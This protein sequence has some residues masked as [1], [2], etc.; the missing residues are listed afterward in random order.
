M[1]KCVIFT[2]K[3]FRQLAKEL[4]PGVVYRLIRYICFWRGKYF[5][6]RELSRRKNLSIFDV[7]ELTRDMDLVTRE[8]GYNAFYG[9]NIIINK[10]IG[11]RG[12]VIGSIEHGV[13]YTGQIDNMTRRA[14]IIYVMSAER[15][16]FIESALWGVE[17]CIAVGPYI[18]YADAILSEEELSVKRKQFGKTLLVL[19]AHSTHSVNCQF[20]IMAF[21]EEIERVRRCHNYDMVLVCMYWKD[22]LNGMA[23]LFENKNWLL[24]CAGH[25][26]DSKFLDRL[27]TIIELS[28]LAMSNTFGTNIGYCV[29]LGKPYY[30]FNQEI[31][32][33]Q[34]DF[35]NNYYNEILRAAI[36]CFGEYKEYISEA[37]KAFVER[38]WGK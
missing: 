24:C 28:D 2:K 25:I 30:L 29:T 27:R 34:E 8:Y 1:E 19:P 6:D 17:K 23:K 35:H 10:A 33:G 18:K 9:L 11:S 21:I 16:R 15:K 5:Y 3:I 31:E 36:Q 32:Y 4:L 37:D 14:D 26:Y 13:S 7:D 20:D 22:Y 12:R 38:Y